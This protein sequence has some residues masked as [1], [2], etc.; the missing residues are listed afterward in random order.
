[1]DWWF[2]SR[3]QSSRYGSLPACVLLSLHRPGCRQASGRFL[4]LDAFEIFQ[5]A[6]AAFDQVIAERIGQRFRIP[7]PQRRNHMQMLMLS[8]VARMPERV[9][10]VEQ[11]SDLDP[12]PFE[13]LDELGHFR[14]SIDGEVELVIGQQRR[15]IV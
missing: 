15:W 6:A 3:R 9:E 14:S 5:E 1:A 12:Q 8:L 4:R 13:N 2:P 10:E 7:V 11:R